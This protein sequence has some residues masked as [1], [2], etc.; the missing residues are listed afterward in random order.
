MKRGVPI[1][2]ATFTLLL[3]LVTACGGGGSPTSTPTIKPTAT[4]TPTSPSQATSIP[5]NTPTVGAAT[6]TPTTP[7]GGNAGGVVSLEII[8]PGDQLKYDIDYMSAPVGSTVV[9]TYTNNSSVFQHNWVL[10]EAGTKDEVARDGGTA[11][12]ASAY[13]PPNDERVL[14]ATIPLVEPGEQVEL[15]FDAPP[16]GLYEFV[17]TFPGHNAT[18]FGT[19]EVK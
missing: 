10:V 3:V 15:T 13:V 14:A 19:F 7:S 16:A 8:T 17:C 6:A 4:P 18:K 11:G 2:L 9:V 5:T 1:V 12:D